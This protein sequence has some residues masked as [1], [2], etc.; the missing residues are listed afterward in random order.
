MASRAE[1]CVQSN[2]RANGPA[3]GWLAK[4]A[5]AAASEPPQVPCTTSPTT[6]QVSDGAKPAI[7]K[8][9]ANPSCARS[10]ERLRP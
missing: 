6:S 3:C 5:L 1:Y 10:S 2:A 7:A 9:S 4:Y 8:P